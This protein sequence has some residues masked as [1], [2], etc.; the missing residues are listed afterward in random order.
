VTR[1]TGFLAIAV[2]V[3]ACSGAAPSPSSSAPTIS[4][5]VCLDVIAAARLGHSGST[6]TFTDPTTGAMED[7]RFPARLSTRVVSGRGE[8]L[9]SDGTVIG[10]EG[11]VLTL[12]GGGAPFAVCAVNGMNYM[13]P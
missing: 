12:G 3:G 1:P 7:L 5:S 13:V 11:D 2:L 8:L 4:G 10:S 6:V 9:T